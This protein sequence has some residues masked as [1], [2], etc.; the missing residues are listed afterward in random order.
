VA[1]LAIHVLCF[2]TV[3]EHLNREYYTICQNIRRKNL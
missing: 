2:S 3:H 1:G